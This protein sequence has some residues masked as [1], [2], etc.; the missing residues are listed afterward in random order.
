MN[1]LLRLWNDFDAPAI[2]YT[3]Q[4]IEIRKRC[5]DSYPC[6]IAVHAFHLQWINNVTW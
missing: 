3:V 2:T 1:V 5:K 4:R 6:V